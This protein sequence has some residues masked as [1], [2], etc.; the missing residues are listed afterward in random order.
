[1]TSDEGRALAPGTCV[2]YGTDPRDRGIVQ[3]T[4]GD[5]VRI[6]WGR[7][8]DDSLHRVTNL[9]RVHRWQPG[10]RRLPHQ[11]DAPIAREVR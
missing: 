6:R 4:T 10:L 9:A 3:A 7:D 8:R 2:Y 5:V 1:M 11:N